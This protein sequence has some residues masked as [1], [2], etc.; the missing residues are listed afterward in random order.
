MP[1][2]HDL[3]QHKRHF[4]VSI[5]NRACFGETLK[6]KPVQKVSLPSGTLTCLPYTRGH[7]A[8]RL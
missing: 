2:N 3:Y 8:I 4:V 1:W 6:N 7:I 5:S